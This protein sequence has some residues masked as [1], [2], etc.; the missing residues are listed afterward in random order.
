MAVFSKVHFE[1]YKFC[2]M[3]LDIAQKPK[4]PGSGQISFAK[5]ELKKVTKMFNL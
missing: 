3:F 2:M 4:T 1:E 5:H